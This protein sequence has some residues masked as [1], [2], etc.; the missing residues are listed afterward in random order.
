MQTSRPW[1]G[2]RPEFPGQPARKGFS[3]ARRAME[4]SNIG[5]ESLNDV[6]MTDPVLLK[7]FSDYV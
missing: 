1:Y 6:P 4:R 7:V 2:T 3:A 5:A